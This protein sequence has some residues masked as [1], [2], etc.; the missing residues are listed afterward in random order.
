MKAIVASNN[1]NIISWDIR[2]LP[3]MIP[4]DNQVVVHIKSAGLNMID[5]YINPREGY[6]CI[7]GLEASGIIE[8]IGK[9]VKNVKSGDRV[10]YVGQLGSF[11]EFN[12]V[13]SSRLILIPPELSFEAAASCFFN[14]LAAFYI[15]N[16]YYHIKPGDHVLVQASA[17]DVGLILVQLLKRLGAYVIAL[18]KSLD[19]ATASIEA[20][21]DE[22]I[23]Y[24]YFKSLG[25]MDAVLE[26]K[27]YIFLRADSLSGFHRC[28]QFDIKD[29]LSLSR[30][31]NNI[32]DGVL[33]GWI[34][35]K[36]NRAFS[37]EQAAVARR[38]LFDKSV[39]GK[40]IFNL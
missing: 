2:S 21:A 27:K 13:D 36:I 37:L 10:A 40:L 38:I 11:A 34:N 23:Y 8:D 6:S 31:E 5:A 9:N 22:I 26:K 33:E 24:S 20:G 18:V 3:E 14:G 16:K 35:I 29:V 39:V 25:E 12:I 7:P 1:K 28:F 30:A 4:N 15:I 17:G 19:C 32:I